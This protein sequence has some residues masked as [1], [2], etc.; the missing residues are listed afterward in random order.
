MDQ[1]ETKPSANNDEIIVWDPLTRIFHWGLVIAFTVAYFSGEEIEA[2]HVWSGYV[3]GGL[4]VFRLL[5]GVVGPKHARFTDFVTAPVKAWRYFFDLVRNRSQRHVGH[6]P[7]GGWMVLVLLAFLALIV[8]SGMSWQADIDGTGPV[9]YLRGDTAV[10]E[11]AGANAVAQATGAA[12]RRSRRRKSVW[13]DIHE[14]SVN[15]GLLLVFL[16]IG[17]VLIAS[18]AHRENLVRSMITGR[19]RAP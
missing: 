9:A 4:I 7:A 1:S 11:A 3:V 19:K 15:F 17:G 5:W 2:L 6:S 10:T 8:W 14:A 12:D 13:H 16:H 18:V